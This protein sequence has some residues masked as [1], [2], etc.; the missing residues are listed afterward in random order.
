MAVL[1]RL[2]MQDKTKINSAIKHFLMFDYLKNSDEKNR[3]ENIIVTSW[4]VGQHDSEAVI[5]LEDI[6]GDE[7]FTLTKMPGLG[8]EDLTG[9][10]LSLIRAK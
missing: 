8:Y 4:H 2:L 1:Y 9:I 3:I 6:S 7:V 10:N 5:K